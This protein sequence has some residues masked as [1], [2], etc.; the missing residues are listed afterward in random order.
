[1][2]MTTVFQKLLCC[3][4]FSVFAI[5]SIYAASLLPEIQAYHSL[6]SRGSNYSTIAGGLAIRLSIQQLGPDRWL[7]FLGLYSPQQIGSARGKAAGWTFH[8]HGQ[9]I[10]IGIYDQK[11]LVGAFKGA[12]VALRHLEWAE[13]HLGNKTGKIS[14]DVI[15]LGW[16]AGST[17]MFLLGLD[18]ATLHT[19][20]G[21][22]MELQIALGGRLAF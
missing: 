20:R 21:T 5:S 4:I 17:F 2:T 8:S 6:G 13:T 22:L 1:M 11:R 10:E 18:F 9:G 7:H 3:I 15:H 12:T 19:P 16:T 14:S